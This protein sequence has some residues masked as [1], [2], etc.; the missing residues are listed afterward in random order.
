MPFGFPNSNLL[1][2]LPAAVLASSVFDQT[3]E[4]GEFDEAVGSEFGAVLGRG[5]GIGFSFLCGRQSADLGVQ[6]V[7]LEDFG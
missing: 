5:E 2:L 6:A 4:I 1:A 7:D 3:A